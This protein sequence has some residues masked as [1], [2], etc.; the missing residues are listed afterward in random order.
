MGALEARSRKQ[1]DLRFRYC[2]CRFPAR[3]YPQAP[4]RS[5]RTELPTIQKT[6]SFRNRRPVITLPICLTSPPPFTA[7]QPDTLVRF[8]PSQALSKRIGTGTRSVSF[9]PLFLDGLDHSLNIALSK[10]PG[11]IAPISALERPVTYNFWAVIINENTLESGIP[12]ER[13]CFVHVN[14]PSVNELLVEFR[15][16]S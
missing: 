12:I 6:S 16:T 14:V 8:S 11:L 13:H 10:D 3:H 9:I 1:G 7:L 15:N 2:T 5:N 4:E